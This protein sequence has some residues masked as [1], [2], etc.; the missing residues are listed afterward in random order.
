[1]ITWLLSEAGPQEVKGDEVDQDDP[2]RL[3]QDVVTLPHE[4]QGGHTFQLQLPP[5]PRGGAMVHEAV[6]HVPLE[7]GHVEHQQTLALGAEA[8]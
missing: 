6:R 8:P 2:A 7:L 3:V 1:M 5:V 4:A